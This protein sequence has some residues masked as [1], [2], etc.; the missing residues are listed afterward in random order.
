M[1]NDQQNENND[2]KYKTETCNSKYKLRMGEKSTFK[3]DVVDRQGHCEVDK[4]DIATEPLNQVHKDSSVDA[5]NKQD[6]ITQQDIK[7]VCYCMTCIIMH[8]DWL[9]SK[10]A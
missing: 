9:E 8:T 7:F 3:N 1:W 5:V 2:S 10:V 4:R 6:I